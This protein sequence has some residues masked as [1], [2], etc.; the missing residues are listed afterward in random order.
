MCT[1]RLHL[2]MHH[3]DHGTRNSHGAGTGG[4]NDGGG[5]MAL[6]ERIQAYLTPKYVNRD[7]QLSKQLR[8]NKPILHLRP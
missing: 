5:I 3:S 1:V 7:F 4:A 6:D 8:R 2:I